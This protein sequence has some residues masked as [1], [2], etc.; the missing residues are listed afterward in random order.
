M[1]KYIARSQS[2]SHLQ[3]DLKHGLWYDRYSYTSNWGLLEYLTA[4]PYVHE[5][6]WMYKARTF[7]NV[8]AEF[9]TWFYAKSSYIQLRPSL[10]SS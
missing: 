2:A 4:L 7:N 10:L 9:Q 6:P 3:C 8:F 5:I 1:S